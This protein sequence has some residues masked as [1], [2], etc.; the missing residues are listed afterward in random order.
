MAEQ[1]IILGA[2]CSCQYGYP[3]ARDTRQHLSEF[4]ATLGSD[5]V[6]LAQLVNETVSV[7]DD[8]RAKGTPVE[9]LDE[10]AW[11]IHQLRNRSEKG[12]H[13]V[14]RAKVAVAALFLSKEAQA[15][16]TGLP[17]YRSLMRRIFPSTMGTDC[18]RALQRTPYRILTFNY[19]RLFELAFRQYFD[20]DHT[21]SFYGPTRLNSG[22]RVADLESVEIDLNRFSFLKLHGS[23]GLY[24]LDWHGRFEHQ[25]TCP[26]PAQRCPFGKSA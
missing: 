26:D 17:A 20:V 19:D 7:F 24:S 15:I 2:G 12:D 4:A 16:Q 6:R 11:Q 21:E 3:L 13:A 14:E 5:A 18:K 25:H 9:T 10:L 1:L 8:L 22:L 23:V